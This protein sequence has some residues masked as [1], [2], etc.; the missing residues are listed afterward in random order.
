MPAIRKFFDAT[1][2]TKDID[3]AARTV[4]GFISTES[5]DRENEVVVARGMDERNFR[6]NPV[7]A[8][9][10]DY[11]TPPIGRNLW[12]KP[13]KIGDTNG[14]IAK[15]E[16]AQTPRAEEIWQLRK[17][18][19]MKGYSIGF[20]PKS[21]KYGMPTD[22]ELKSMP[23]WSAARCVIRE[24]ELLEYSDVLIPCNQDALSR[25]YHSKSLQLSAELARDLHIEEP[26]PVEKASTKVY[27]LT[28]TALRKGLAHEL[29]ELDLKEITREICAG[30]PAIVTEQFRLAKGGV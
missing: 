18:G 10:H 7:V 16:Y 21:G 26:P 17:G 1:V 8:W 24:W 30:I 4:V 6:S 27:F 29:E 20:L 22:S 11:K 23:A 13:G 9:C 3:E 25:A 14:L 12:I 5:I 19:F 15:T 2:E 28:D